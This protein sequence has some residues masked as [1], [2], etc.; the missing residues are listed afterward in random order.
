MI[1]AL[2]LKTFLIYSIFTQVLFTVL[3]RC[4]QAGTTFAYLCRSSSSLS[5]CFFCFFI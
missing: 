5:L 1:M 3:L 2:F 4:R